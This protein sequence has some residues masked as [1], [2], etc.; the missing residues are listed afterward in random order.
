MYKM[1]R[2]NTIQVYSCASMGIFT[3]VTQQLDFIS[4]WNADAPVTMHCTDEYGNKSNYSDVVFLYH[5][6]IENPGIDRHG[7]QMAIDIL[8]YG[9]HLALQA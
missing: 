4:N 2:L 3:N 7:C 5:D 6:E 1:G 8:L 9:M